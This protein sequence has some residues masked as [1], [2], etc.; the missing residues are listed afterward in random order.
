MA[1]RPTMRLE[2]MIEVFARE[3]DMLGSV[4]SRIASPGYAQ[5]ALFPI[6]LQ[7]LD[8]H[9][10]ALK[11]FL[12]KVRDLSGEQRRDMSAIG[13]PE[14]NEDATDEERDWDKKLATRRARLNHL[15]EQKAPDTIVVNE[16]AL[17][18]HAALKAGK[19]QLE[20]LKV[21]KKICADLQG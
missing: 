12:D 3:V 14:P 8:R 4:T 9:L 19:T 20:T 10:K 21:L 15:I 18:S 16:C 11:E 13:N 17:V 6:D 5:D 1:W 7:H 2:D